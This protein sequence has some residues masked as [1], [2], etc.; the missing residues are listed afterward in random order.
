[1]RLYFNELSPVAVY[2]T[3]AKKLIGIFR[4]KSIASEFIY[5]VKKDSKTL[6][7]Y[8]KANSKIS[9]K[10]HR[11]NCK[12]LIRDATTAQQKECGDK[13]F[14]LKDNRFDHFGI[15]LSK[16]LTKS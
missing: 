7:S 5:G 3:D 1:M 13:P 10:S 4:S 15:L 14:I 9:K 6:S 16:K 11:L 12:I 2:D 8:I